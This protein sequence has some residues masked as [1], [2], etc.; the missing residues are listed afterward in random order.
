MK[1]HVK[2]AWI[3]RMRELHAKG[4]VPALSVLRNG[5]QFCWLGLLCDTI[6]S[7]RWY[8]TPSDKWRYD[9]P[10]NKVSYVLIPDEILAAIGLPERAVVDGM[11]SNDKARCNW[12]QL[13]NYTELAIPVT[14]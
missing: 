14:P 12:G 5:S 11:I 13:A 9:F 1:A 8:L 7:T 10:N 4:E 3:R 6:D 2:V